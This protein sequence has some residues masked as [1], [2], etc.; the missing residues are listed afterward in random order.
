MDTTLLLRRR[1]GKSCIEIHLPVS[2]SRTLCR[3]KLFGFWT[4]FIP[5]C[6][7]ASSPL[8]PSQWAEPCSLSTCGKSHLSCGSGK[9]G[10]SFAKETL[11]KMPM[12]EQLTSV[13]PISLPFLSP[14]RRIM[15]PEGKQRSH[16]SRGKTEGERGQ[17]QG[18]PSPGNGQV[19]GV[20]LG[21]STLFHFLTFLEANGSSGHLFTA[22]FAAMAVI[23]TLHH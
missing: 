17:A 15:F 4:E 13:L 12:K 19:L 3:Q 10:G 8:P 14:T 9:P 1:S 16:R 7:P 18:W 21:P 22:C 5:V 23:S 11:T 2:W 6:S 20:L